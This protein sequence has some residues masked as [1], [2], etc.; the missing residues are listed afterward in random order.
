MTTLK[1][2]SSFKNGA[3]HFDDAQSTTDKDE[4]LCF[5][6]LTWVICD[7]CKELHCARLMAFGCKILELDGKLCDQVASCERL[8]E[9]KSKKRVFCENLVEPK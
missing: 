7:W 5:W 4:T 9:R 3:P 2:L 6:K 8:C 1:Q